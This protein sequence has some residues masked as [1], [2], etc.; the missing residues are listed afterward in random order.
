MTADDGVRAT[1]RPGPGAPSSKCSV[2]LH[3]SLS[4]T[5]SLFL[6][7][8]VRTCKFLS[9]GLFV[10]FLSVR[11]SLLSSAILLILFPS[12]FPHDPPCLCVS[13]LFF[14]SA[15]D[16]LNTSKKVFFKTNNFSCKIFVN[17]F[18]IENLSVNNE[19]NIQ[20]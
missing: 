13:P 11:L 2:M 12:L 1:Y 17:V 8:P 18:H 3:L 9:L 15:K 16:K 4:I 10:C 20:V 14:F 5:P 6:V 19:S 7:T